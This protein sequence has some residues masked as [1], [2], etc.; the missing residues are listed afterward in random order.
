M[1][2]YRFNPGQQFIWQGKR[3]EVKRVIAPDQRVNLECL[4][5]GILLLADMGVLIQEFF[6]GNL[7]FVERNAVSSDRPSADLDLA[8]YPVEDVEIARWRLQVIQPI[9]DLPP[10]QQT[11]KA[12]V[13]HVKKIRAS[14]PAGTSRKLSQVVS[15][16]TLYRWLKIYRLSGNDV[17][18]LLPQCDERGGVGKSRLKSEVDSLVQAVLKEYYLRAEPIGM[19]DLVALIAARIEE[20]NRLRPKGHHLVIPSRAT[21]ARRME[22]LDI[23]EK[24]TAQHGRRT[25]AR[26][27]RQAEQMMYPD[28]PYERVEIDHTRCDVIVIDERDSLPLG[29]P[30]LTY[31]L[32]L[33]T[34]YPLG[35]YLGFEPPSYFT[36]MECLHHAICAKEDVH[37]KYGAEHNWQAYGI[38]GTLVVDNG[39]EFIGQDLSDA[40]AQLGIV[41]QQCPVMSPEFKAGVE[42]HFGTLNSGVFHTLPGTTFSNMF[43]RGEYDSVQRACISLNELEK[44]LT[45]FLVDIYAERRHRGLNGVPA[46]RW[47][48]SWTGD[49]IPRLPPSRDE[50][51]ILLG[52]VEWRV[53]H[54]YGIELESLRYNASGLGELR[55]RL[56]GEKV[57]LKYH[58]GDLS[59]IYIFDPFEKCYHELP[60]LTPEY[61]QGLSIWKHRLI[62]RTAS[63][64]KEAVDLASL[65][66]ARQKI[67]EMVDRARTR[68][69]TAT[70]SKVARWDGK[71]TQGSLPEAAKTDANLTQPTNPNLNAGLETE[72]FEFDYDLPP[73]RH[74]E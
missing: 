2:S 29:R 35:F 45:I 4:E 62:R 24:M 73:S 26:K 37:E 12:V 60:S 34:R 16:T 23:Q 50:L 14:F 28:R 64:E 39:K 13:E 58:P 74:D 72:L 21:I 67:Q 71:T 65:G 48:R 68:K 66:K 33:A 36:V 20:E 9:L 53:L 52:K 17:R 44:A 22:A 43:E 38:P 56:R 63:Q 11:E 8:S 69:K 19:D 51:M 59:R 57:K 55:E 15:R 40:C 42:R 6:A 54:S 32:D 61:T 10:D 47:E 25:T 7:W 41:L 18:S 70:R 5:N 31:C 1:S 49:F 27:F 30:T 3:Y 46:R